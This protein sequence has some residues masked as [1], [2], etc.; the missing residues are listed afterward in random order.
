MSQH[1][2]PAKARVSAVAFVKSV[3]IFGSAVKATQRLTPTIANANTTEA[4]RFTC[5]VLEPSSIIVLAK[6]QFEA[7]TQK[8]SRTGR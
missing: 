8:V 6:L 3:T 1:D 2:N 4:A 5:E 7:S